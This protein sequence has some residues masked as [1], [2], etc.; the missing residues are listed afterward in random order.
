MPVEVVEE[1]GHEGSPGAILPPAV[2]AVVDGLPR[3]VAFGDIAPRC[4]G[5]Q[6]PEDAME[7]AV[8][9]QPRVAPTA[10]VPRMGQQGRQALPLSGA[11]FV[12]ASHGRPPQGTKA[13]GTENYAAKHM[14]DRA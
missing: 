11:E 8:V 7:S 5:V 3:A 4:A 14:P 10:V 13:T 1:F 6:D 12:T 9:R 2:E